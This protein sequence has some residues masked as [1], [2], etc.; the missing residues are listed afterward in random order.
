MGTLTI[1]IDVP[2]GS[3]VSVGGVNPAREPASAGTG[4]A[5]SARTGAPASAGAAAPAS[6]ATAAA[7]AGQ[8]GKH[9]SLRIWALSSLERAFFTFAAS[10]ASAL[11]LSKA[12]GIPAVDA[13]LFAGASAA[14]SVVTAA[15]RSLSPPTDDKALDVVTRVG[16][17]VLQAFTAAFMTSTAGAT[18]F[19]DWRAGALAGAAAAFTALKGTLAVQL[20]GEKATPASLIRLRTGGANNAGVSAET[21]L[22]RPGLLG[23]A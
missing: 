21:P 6:G 23:G 10:F 9:V 5:A 22:T 2:E 14:L 11:L 1:S 16:L 17:T 4:E 8:A 18:H 20:G 13:A 15:I 7:T 3:Q 12:F 19:S